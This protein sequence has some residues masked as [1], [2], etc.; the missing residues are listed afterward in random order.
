VSFATDTPV[1]PQRSVRAAV[2]RFLRW[3]IDR[4]GGES[5]TELH[6]RVLRMHARSQVSGTRESIER[7][8]C[9]ELPLGSS[10]DFIWSAPVCPGDSTRLT[11]VIR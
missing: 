7:A 1:G 5:D 2:V 3:L 4:L 10:A 9:G 8:V 11:V 6:A